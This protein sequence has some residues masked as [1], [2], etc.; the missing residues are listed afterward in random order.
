M[1]WPMASLQTWRFNK[2]TWGFRV[3]GVGL[4]DNMGPLNVPSRR[5]NSHNK[6]PN[7][8]LQVS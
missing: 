3:S 7:K 6:D 8:V 5:I 2:Q 4:R 1:P